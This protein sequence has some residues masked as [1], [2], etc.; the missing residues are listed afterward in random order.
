M[1]QFLTTLVWLLAASAVA[2]PLGT[3]S[4]RGFGLDASKPA[5]KRHAI[6]DGFNTKK[7]K[8]PLKQRHSVTRA[9]KDGHYTEE[10]SEWLAQ[11][12]QSD[13]N[14]DGLIDTAAALKAVFGKNDI[15]WVISGGFALMLY[16]E[17]DRTTVDIDCVVQ[18]T[19]PRLRNLLEA[20]GRFIIPAEDWWVDSAHLQVYFNDNGKYYDV[21]MV[22]AGK[23]N[24][25]KDLA[26]V[27]EWVPATKD[28]GSQATIPL[29]KIS[30]MFK[31][32]SFALASPKRN[33]VKGDMRDLL[34]MM[35]T[36]P[37]DLV[38]IPHQLPLYHR[39]LII[40]HLVRMGS[41]WVEQAKK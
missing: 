11:R 19:M 14:T 38:N 18:T 13:A 31:A 2:S 22:I 23:K 40:S 5:L 39:E 10:E 6:T 28:D 21:D 17:P 37:E 24:S 26:T 30:Q 34:W 8:L 3:P 41:N 20:D 12:V 33:K 25:V 36:H 9:I 35:Q 27:R 7:T 29:Q 1:W 32:R 15:P 16:G 4:R